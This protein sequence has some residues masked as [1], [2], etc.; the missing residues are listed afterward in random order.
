MTNM[1]WLASIGTV[2]Y[3]LY[4]NT[5]YSPYSPYSPYTLHHTHIHFTPYSRTLYNILTIVAGREITMVSYEMLEVVPAQGCVFSTGC[6]VLVGLLCAE[7]ARVE[8]EEVLLYCT[9]YT[10]LILYSYC[11]HT[12]L[13]SYCTVLTPYCTRTVLCS[14]CTRTVLIL[15]TV[16]IL[17]S[18]CTQARQ[19][20]KR[21]EARAKQMRRRT[22]TDMMHGA[23]LPA[24]GANGEGVGGPTRI[25]SGEGGPPASLEEEGDAGGGVAGAGA[26]GEDEL[27]FGSRPWRA[28]RR[29]QVAK[30]VQTV[31]IHYTH[32]A[33]T[34]YSHTTHTAGGESSADPALVQGIRRTLY[35]VHYTHTLYSHSAGTGHPLLVGASAASYAC[36]N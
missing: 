34:L 6:T 29:A 11:T 31:V 13:H 26:G 20:A 30:A 16:L 22:S 19:S 9:L 12:V 8:T 36:A 18:Y 15:Y 5:P 10:V 2:P 17:H 23:T 32:Y 27:L 14:Y 33:H 7:I 3:S 25:I 21:M 28:M 35:T 4:T 24:N 1:T